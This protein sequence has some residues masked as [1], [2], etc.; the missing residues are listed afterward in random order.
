MPLVWLLLLSSLFGTSLGCIKD[1]ASAYRFTGTVCRLTHPAAVV[2]N[3]KTTKVIEAAFQHARYPSMKGEKS[4]LFTGKVL[5]GLDNLEIHNLSIGQSEFEFRPGE[6]VDLKISN[7][8]AIF[9]GTIKYGYGSWLVNVAHSV[10]FEIDSHIDLGINPK[11]YCGNGKVAV[12]TSDCYLNFHKLHLLLQGDREPNWLK[13]IFTN[14]I[15]FTVKVVVKAQICKEIN[16]V[17]NVLADF[18]QDTAERFLSDGDISVNINLTA[19]PVITPTYIESYHKGLTNYHNVTA[20]INDSVFHPSQLTEHRMLY[21]WF[22]DQVMNPMVAAAHHDGRFQLNISGAEFTELFKANFSSSTPEFFNK[23]LLESVSP[24]LKLWSSSVPYLKT[25]S[26]GT[27]VWAEAS[28]ELYCGNP[29]TPTLFFQT[30]VVTV[31]TT[32][33]ADKKVFLKGNASKVSVIQAE[34]S[35]HDQQ[36]NETLA[37]FIKE[38]VKKVGVPKILSVLRVEVTRLLDQQG[39]NLFDIFNPE[40]L[41]RDGFVVIQMDFGFPHHLL[42]EFL[43]RTL[44]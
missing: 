17:A 31:V 33:Y 34:L 18:I 22:S 7:V 5:Y 26:V 19:D 11:L 16:K 30:E 14:F 4:L 36:L 3:E 37:E 21:F 15:T 2:L 12:D 38:A 40:V 1:P 35:S 27:T 24:E 29:H 20:V 25:S 6:G 8:S 44:Q 43:S 13:R 39:T 10:D 32:F 42:V 23:C 41:P 28:G 9:R